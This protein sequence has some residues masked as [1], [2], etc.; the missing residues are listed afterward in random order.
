MVAKYSGTGNPV[1]VRLSA[2]GYYY[3]VGTQADLPKIA[4][5]TSDKAPTPK[6]KADA[7]DCDWKCVV[8]GAKGEETKEVTTL[9]EFVEHCV[10]PAME[11][12]KP[13]K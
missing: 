5:Y 4:S 1:P 10:K 6:C 2:L 11:K 13:L 9:G 7:K 3:N 12:R 8:Q